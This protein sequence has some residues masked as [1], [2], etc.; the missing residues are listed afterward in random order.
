[1]AIIKSILL[2]FLFVILILALYVSIYI[3]SSTDTK[4]AEIEG[5]VLDGKTNRPIENVMISIKNYRYE[6][7]DG[8]SNYDEY[9]GLDS[10][11]IY[12]NTKGYFYHKFPKSAFVF[13]ILTKGGY[14]TLSKDEYSRRKMFYNIKLKPS[15]K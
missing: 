4:N 15:L 7:D 13:F 10:I 3:F 1:M 5:Y 8:Y 2:F 11:T 6:S 12:T 9:L 14:D